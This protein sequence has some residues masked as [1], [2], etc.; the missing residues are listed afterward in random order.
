M[1]SQL[2]WEMARFAVT[3]IKTQRAHREPRG[4]WGLIDGKRH[5]GSRPCSG[6][7]AWGAEPLQAG[8]ELLKGGQSN[9]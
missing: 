7:L 5:R 9:T 2:A 3:L 8:S 1:E 6:G 4:C